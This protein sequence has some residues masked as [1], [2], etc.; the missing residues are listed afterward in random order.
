MTV[1]TATRTYVRRSS[2]RS[3]YSR[4][5]LSY[6]PQCAIADMCGR[7]LHM[8][9]ANEATATWGAELQ[10]GTLF[11][12]AHT[13]RAPTA[14]PIKANYLKIVTIRPLYRDPMPL[15]NISHTAMWPLPAH[16]RVIHC[17][18]LSLLR[19]GHPLLLV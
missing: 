8:A 12:W 18:I 4:P 5:L 10:S 3:C 6:M 19:L 16:V 17:S 9:T 15:R 13:Q 7:C 14:W 11:A 1:Y 2:L